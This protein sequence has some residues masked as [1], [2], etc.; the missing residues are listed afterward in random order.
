M[1]NK[2]AQN[3]TDPDLIWLE[4][5]ATLMDNQFRIPG[6]SLRFGLDSLLGFVPYVGD[7]S[8]FVVST[9]LMRT[10]VK[11]G[12]GLGLMFKMFGNV[13][14]DSLVGLVPILGDFFDIGFKANR[15]NVELLKKYYA[16]GKPRPSAKWA[17]AILAV[18]FLAFFVGLILA[19]GWVVRWAWHLMF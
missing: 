4:R 8:G 12:A 13:V 16:S 7:L 9:I 15:R 18:L 5:L 1:D 14:L 3:P 17:M 2:N 6:T 10:M 19:A 11:K